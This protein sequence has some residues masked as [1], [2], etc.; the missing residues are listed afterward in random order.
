MYT[1]ETSDLLTTFIGWAFFLI[2]IGGGLAGYMGRGKPLVMPEILQDLK[3]DKIQLGY[4]DDNVVVVEEKEDEISEIKKEIQLIKLKKELHALKNE[5]SR[6][7]DFTGGCIEAMVALGTKKS[8][9]KQKVFDI[10]GNHPEIK[11]IE[12][13]IQKAFQS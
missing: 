2:L 7:D 4:I 8:E 13:F 5:T 6:G 9:A 3:D 12:E 11:T 1:A 10:L